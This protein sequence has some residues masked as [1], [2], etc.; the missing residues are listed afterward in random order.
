MISRGGVLDRLRMTECQSATP[1]V[2]NP[3]VTFIDSDSLIYAEFINTACILNLARGYNDNRNSIYE[4]VSCP[5]P[6]LLSSGSAATRTR[7]DA[8]RRSLPGYYR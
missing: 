3:W 7:L 5:P 6:A 8:T 2:I 1:Y 4:R